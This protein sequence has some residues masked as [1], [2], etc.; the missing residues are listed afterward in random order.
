MSALFWQAL[1]CSYLL[2]QTLRSNVMPILVSFIVIA[3]IIIIFPLA[4]LAFILRW[5]VML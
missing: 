1:C 5:G 4:F 3:V 2:H